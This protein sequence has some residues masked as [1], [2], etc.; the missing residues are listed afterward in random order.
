[1]REA[2]VILRQWGVSDSDIESLASILRSQD[3]DV[4][5]GQ[6]LEKSIDPIIVQGI[7][8]VVRVVTDE[9]LRELVRLTW[10]TVLD[11][12]R[13]ISDKKRPTRVDVDFRAP[14]PDRYSGAL[15]FRIQA[16]TNEPDAL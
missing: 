4:E 3:F 5:T 16:R 1:M 14:G 7:W 13:A 2:R 6:T 10:H 11:R 8:F 15:E 12:I 9:S